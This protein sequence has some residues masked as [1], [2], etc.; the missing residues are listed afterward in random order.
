LEDE[1]RNTKESL[2]LIESDMR[3]DPYFGGD[4][5]F[6]HGARMIEAK[7]KLLDEEIGTYLPSLES[8]LKKSAH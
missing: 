2:P 7:L 8:Q 4:H 1:R 3:L 6:S 5:T